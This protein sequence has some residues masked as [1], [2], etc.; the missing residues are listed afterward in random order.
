MTAR[1][2]NDDNVRDERHGAVARRAGFPIAGHILQWRADPVKLLTEAA[3]QGDV[4]R[5]ALP[6]E[7]YFL[8]HPKHVKHVLQDNHQNYC[9][10]WVFDRI[11]PYWGESLLTADGDT[12]RQQRRRVQPS[13]K[14]DHTP[15]SRRSS[16]A[17]RR[18]ARALGDARVSRPGA[19]RSTTR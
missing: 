19:A 9:K 3:R 14:R 16:R 5:L 15:V 2:M 6:G 12:W 1:V 13:F 10:G 11:K 8:S 7:T 18:D 4:V 17:H